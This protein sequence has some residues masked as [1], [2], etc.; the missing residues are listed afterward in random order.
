MSVTAI[1]VSGLGGGNAALAN[2]A[3]TSGA[4]AN[5]A[6]VNVSNGAIE[7]DV[8]AA[9]IIPVGAADG[10]TGEFAAAP[11]DRS[12]SAAL[13]LSM[14]Q[15]A[16]A[17]EATAQPAAKSTETIAGKGTAFRSQ[18]QAHLRASTAGAA[19]Q[20]SVRSRI[21]Q[22]AGTGGQL[23][24]GTVEEAPRALDPG[25]GATERKPAMNASALQSGVSDAQA[26]PGGT[27]NQVQES[28]E[29]ITSSPQRVVEAAAAPANSGVGIAGTVAETRSETEEESDASGSTPSMQKK[30]RDG[31]RL[32]PPPSA[33]Q[34]T[35][36]EA[37]AGCAEWIALPRTTYPAPATDFSAAG[38]PA[39]AEPARGGRSGT[40]L[41]TVAR[42]QSGP[43][44][45]M[46]AAP[47]PEGASQNS[48]DDQPA[49]S[50]APPEP[51]AE[52]LQGTSAATD[53][54]AHKA[55]ELDGAESEMKNGATAQRQDGHAVTSLP[56]DAVGFS[57]ND[58]GSEV[59]NQS[60]QNVVKGHQPERI[61]SEPGLVSATV[62]PAP[63]SSHAVISSPLAHV[64]A[65]GQGVQNEVATH[66]ADG[67]RI[68]AGPSAGF[69]ERD[70]FTAID[71]GTGVGAPAWVHAGL[72]KA[73]AGF[74]DPQLGWVG[75]RAGMTGSGVQAVVLPG[76][77]EAEQALRTHLSGIS[78]YLSEQHAPVSTLTVAGPGPY[79]F[80]PSTDGR[81]QQNANQ[82][83]AQ[84]SAVLPQ[85]GRHPEPEGI[86][87][88][89]VKA[90]A[91]NGSESPG[92]APLDGWRGSR[93]S[94]MA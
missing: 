51:A 17:M 18:W 26:K 10:A 93:I 27:A 59:N 43:V 36:L 4:M 57:G 73:E 67:S 75:V 89:S 76:S 45:V 92:F 81:G 90:G 39:S 79:G 66:S 87:A 32:T 78:A 56:A 63:L 91:A 12:W 35:T 28:A 9:G 60:T 21:G 5:A 25:A 68:V 71:S 24:S 77:S 85:A 19:A 1:E 65:V 50:P 88:M 80:A 41:N 30:S 42:Q 58:P 11:G 29:S 6:M 33:V 23:W 52:Q 84:G 22:A 48:L 31:Q 82:N 46:E 69:I 83:D 20:L 13:S 94:V 7:N 72:Q 49:I 74:D 14:Q 53:R 47:S 61:A 55:G 54:Q 8:A 64:S 3:T 37:Q 70:V 40:I 16:R 15:N 2:G 86:A 44:S 38:N 62:D 34:A